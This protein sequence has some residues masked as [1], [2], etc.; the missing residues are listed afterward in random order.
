MGVEDGLELN[1]DVLGG[2]VDKDA[3]TLVHGAL[4]A[5]ATRLKGAAKGAANKV[6]NRDLLAR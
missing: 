4:G 3:A 2:G 1:E 6:V 5:L